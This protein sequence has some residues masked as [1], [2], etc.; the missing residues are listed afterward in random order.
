MKNLTNIFVALSV[1]LYRV[2]GGLLGSRLGGQT[3]LLL[4]SVGRKT[5]REYTTPLSFYRDGDSYLVVASNWG[6][7]N[8]PAWFYNLKHQPRT[9]IQVGSKTIPVEAHPAEGSEH[10]RLWALVTHQNKQF[11]DY[12]KGLSR[13]IPVVVLNP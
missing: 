10:E 7:E 11:T 12:Q 9:T 6:R 2:T 8:P 5:G 4:N 13:Q 3:V 1:F